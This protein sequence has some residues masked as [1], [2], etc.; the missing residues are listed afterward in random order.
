MLAD[1]NE[2]SF[3]KVSKDFQRGLLNNADY[4]DLLTQLLEKYLTQTTGSFKI[5][6]IFEGLL[7][8]KEI[9]DEIAEKR[10]MYIIQH[11]K[12]ITHKVYENFLK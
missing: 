2:L 8:S 1:I 6:E 9:L 10:I 7:L 11:N 12:N 4:I 3:E 5:Q